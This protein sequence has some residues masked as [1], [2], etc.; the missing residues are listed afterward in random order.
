V[1]VCVRVFVCACVCACFSLSLS[2]SLSV[3]VCLC[4]CV[5]ERMHVCV[6]VC[7]CVLCVVDKLM[8]RQGSR[9]VARYV[10]MQSSLEHITKSTTLA[11]HN[12]YPQSD[13]PIASQS[14]L[15][16]QSPSNTNLQGP[17]ARSAQG[18]R[19]T[20]AALERVGMPALFCEY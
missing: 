8:A 18:L 15:I 11:K 1:C 13:E 2:L 16:K 17:D 7:V 20:R 14:G 4:A 10:H 5:R 19:A 3:F 9:V 6:R 12:V